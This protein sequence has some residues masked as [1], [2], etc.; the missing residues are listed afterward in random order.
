MTKHLE[1]IHTVDEETRQQNPQ[2]NMP[3]VPAI[4][5]QRGKPVFV[6]GV[7]P[8]P[9]YHSHPH[10]AS[11]FDAIPT[12]PATQAKMT[13]DHLE[14]ILKQAGGT[15]SDVVQIFVFIVDVKK[16]GGII[17]K[18]VTESFGDHRPTSTVVGT[19]GLITDSRFLI[20]VTAT[21]YIE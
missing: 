21:A 3:Y 6:S 1:S 12:D 11:E 10:V 15:L 19:T 8:A 7:N 14:A 13:M 4:R 18:V 9:V 20:E 2:W 16:N 5:V 17:G